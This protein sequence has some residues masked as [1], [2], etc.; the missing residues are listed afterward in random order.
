MDPQELEALVF[1]L[2]RRLVSNGILPADYEER[3][4]A[5]AKELAAGTRG[6]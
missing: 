3:A 2:I 4:I 5:E 6:E 1:V